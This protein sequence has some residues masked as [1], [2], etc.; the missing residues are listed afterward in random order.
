M[1]SFCP[2]GWNE[3]RLN[4]FHYKKAPQQGIFL[5]F[6]KADVSKQRGSGLAWAGQ[7][8]TARA[9]GDL[10]SGFAGLNQLLNGAPERDPGR[11]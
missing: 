11:P 8:D 5:F 1:S 10:L 2:D 7:L 3:Y 6:I 4:K 9:V